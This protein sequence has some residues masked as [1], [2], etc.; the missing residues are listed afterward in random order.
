MG[1]SYH[2]AAFVEVGYLESPYDTSQTRWKARL[3][4]IS[5]DPLFGTPPVI[6]APQP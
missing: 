4:V 3:F 2:P 5:P 6:S 1:P